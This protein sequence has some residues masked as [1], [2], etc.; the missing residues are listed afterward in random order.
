MKVAIVGAGIS[1]L[2][3]A[4]ALHR[5]GLDVTV[6]EKSP[7]VRGG[8]SGITLAPNA[9][10][11]LDS[12]GI[13]A[14]FR[15]RQRQQGSLQGGQRSPRGTWLMRF[16]S[17]LTA[18]SLVIARDELHT[19]LASA[20][21]RDLIRTGTRVEKVAPLT[22][23][24][25]LHDCEGRVRSETFD[26]VVGADGLT[27]AVRKAWPEDP[28]TRYA[29]YAA[30]RGLTKAPFDLNGV[31][32]ETWGTRARF[33]VAPL[34]DGRVYWFGVHTTPEPRRGHNNFE[35]LHRLFDRWH[36]P[37]PEV[38]RAS[39][40]NT[41]QYLPII[42]LAGELR[43][44][45]RGRAVL[46]GDAAHAM[47]PNLGQGACQGLEDAATLAFLVQSVVSTPRAAQSLETVLVKYDRLRRARASAI[48]RSS[49]RI[50]RIAHMGGPALASLRNE[51]LRI[52]PDRLLAGQVMATTRWTPPTTHA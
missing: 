38:I 44:F 24:L 37:I 26:L 18:Q 11:A 10:A 29:G 50:G 21:P 48:A 41:I 43:S 23:T 14:P 28:G 49:R 42:E 25:T 33:G 12:L 6:Y 3:L 47:T 19:L 31:G 35:E 7:T 16:P 20:L 8:G 13:G 5:E 17:D 30:W 45:A 9:L 52:M 2:A 46:I 32:A 22:G 39:S 27:S 40:E 4:A 51:L 1:G 34:Y 36:S 15:E